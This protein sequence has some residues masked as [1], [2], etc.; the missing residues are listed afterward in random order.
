[1]RSLNHVRMLLSAATAFAVGTA[2]L[3]LQA[4]DAVIDTFD[5][6]ATITAWTPTWGTTPA[7]TY[8]TNGNPG[9]AL[10]MAADY[11]TGAGDWEQR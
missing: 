4:Q 10:R 2:A 11:F 7:V 1:M 3:Q 9:G 8:S 6:E 5:T